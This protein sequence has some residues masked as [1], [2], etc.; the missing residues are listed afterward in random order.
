M[1]KFGRDCD[2]KGQE[3][4]EVIV[5]YSIPPT[6]FFSWFFLA[7]KMGQIKITKANTIQLGATQHDKLSVYLD[8]T[9]SRPLG[10]KS[11]ENSIGFL[12]DLRTT[13]FPSEISWPL[14]EQICF[15]RNSP[16]NL[17]FKK[18]KNSCI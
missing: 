13:Q 6:N 3:I 18:H 12:E 16:Y 7:S 11:K 1:K 8:L 14:V 15:R 10:Q 9:H 5:V 17:K 4:S 2:D